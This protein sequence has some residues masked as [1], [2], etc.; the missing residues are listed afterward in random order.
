[1]GLE[2]FGDVGVGHGRL[3]FMMSVAIER[4]GL[5]SHHLQSFKRH[6]RGGV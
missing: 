1:M 3:A 5:T 4:D 2:A 6:L